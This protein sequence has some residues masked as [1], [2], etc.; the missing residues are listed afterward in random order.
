[1]AQSAPG[2]YNLP[3]TELIY[4]LG[5]LLFILLLLNHLAGG[6][7]SNVLRPAAAIVFA[8]SRL[9]F[10]FGF[11][12]IRSVFKLSSHSI[13]LKVPPGVKEDSKKNGATPPRW[14]S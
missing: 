1:M 13:N 4:S 8:A 2:A 3:M 11:A 5:L 10:R 7:P 12:A 14:H 9:C 6:R